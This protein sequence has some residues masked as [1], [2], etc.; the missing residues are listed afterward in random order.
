MIKFRFLKRSSPWLC[1]EW[2]A[3]LGRAGIFGAFVQTGND[4]LLCPS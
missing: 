4:G 3:G 1:G 2:F